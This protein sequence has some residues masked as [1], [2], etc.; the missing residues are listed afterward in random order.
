MEDKAEVNKLTKEIEDEHKNYKDSQEMVYPN[1]K[2]I[3]EMKAL[4]SPPESVIQC[5][6][7]VFI[8]LED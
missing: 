1:I 3:Q 5:M 2:D 7:L 4:K 6:R 8:E